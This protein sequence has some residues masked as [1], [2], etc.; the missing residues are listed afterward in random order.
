MSAKLVRAALTCLCLSAF[1]VAPTAPAQ[2]PTTA[3]KARSPVLEEP[4]EIEAPRDPDILLEQKHVAV[5]RGVGVFFDKSDFRSVMLGMPRELP[6]SRPLREFLADQYG[7]T[8]H[9]YVNGEPVM[10]PSAKRGISWLQD[11]PRWGGYASPRTG[12]GRSGFAQDESSM[13]RSGRGAAA[14]RGSRRAPSRRGGGRGG[15]KVR[16]P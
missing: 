7:Q 3:P 8:I 13:I 10:T 12:R 15:L 11:M 16:H 14:G 1:A 6:S 5:V 2:E 4:M 9:H